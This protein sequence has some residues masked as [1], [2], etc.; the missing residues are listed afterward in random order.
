MP[1]QHIDTHGCMGDNSRIINDLLKQGEY[2]GALEQTISCAKSLNWADSTV[3][4]AFMNTM[5]G[6]SS[7]NNKCIE[8][9]D[10]SVVNP[11]EAIKW[12]ESQSETNDTAP[13]ETTTE[14]ETETG[15]E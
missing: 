9:P 5:Y 8:L 14:N 10:G 2:I 1:N 15:E 3:M 12:L 7:Y 13:A 11:E 6:E 4:R